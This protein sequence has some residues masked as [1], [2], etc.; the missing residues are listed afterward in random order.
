MA[1]EM[2]SFKKFDVRH[3]KSSMKVGVDAVLLGAWVNLEE[4]NEILEVG[5]GCGVISLILAQRNPQ[6][7][8]TAI[9]I[10]KNSIEESTYNFLNSPWKDRLTSIIEEFPNETLKKKKKYDLI[11]SNPPYFS[12]G[13]KQ[14]STSRERAR[15]QDKLSVFSL[16][17]NGSRLLNETGK[18]AVIIP[19]EFLDQSKDLA[20]QLGYSVKRECLM[21]NKDTKPYKRV[22]FE[23]VWGGQKEEGIEKLTLFDSGNPTKEYHNLCKDLYLKF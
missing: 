16:L 20:L 14:P 7:F 18:I 10:D 1:Q 23:F 15:H 8:I 6:S 22:M 9:D 5:T 4:C 21:R 17:E 11:I 3:G 2:F 12:S 19:G 13:I